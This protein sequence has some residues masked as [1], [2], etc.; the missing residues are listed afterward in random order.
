MKKDFSVKLLTLLTLILLC[1]SAFAQDKPITLTCTAPHAKGV[2]KALAKAGAAAVTAAC[3]GCQNVRVTARLKFK[4]KPTK[5]TLTADQLVDSSILEYAAPVAP[6]TPTPIGQ[7]SESDYNPQAAVAG[8]LSIRSGSTIGLPSA[9]C[10][11]DATVDFKV[12]YRSSAGESHK[13]TW[14]GDVTLA[15]AWK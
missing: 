9:A 7:S 1:G 10:S 12:R 14:S 13:S 3:S 15:G 6:P 2:V 5:T 11:V 8:T 4:A